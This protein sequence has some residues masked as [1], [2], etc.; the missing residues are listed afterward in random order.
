[1]SAGGLMLTYG[2]ERSVLRLLREFPLEHLT[3]V[4]IELLD[5][6]WQRE[7]ARAALNAQ[8]D[9]HR[10]TCKICLGFEPGGAA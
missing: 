6:L 3:P 5:L 10:D 7:C 2:Q 9:R 8:S 1:M 4:Q